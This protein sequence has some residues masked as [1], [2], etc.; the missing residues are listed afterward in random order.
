[1][2]FYDPWLAESAELILSLSFAVACLAY[3]AKTMSGVF[4][5]GGKR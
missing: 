3:T 1:M 5:K 4:T 2:F